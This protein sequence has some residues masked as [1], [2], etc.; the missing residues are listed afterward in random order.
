MT[1]WGSCLVWIAHEQVQQSWPN[2]GTVTM[3]LFT[4]ELR[5]VGRQAT[6]TS[7]SVSQGER[8]FRKGEGGGKEMMIS[9]YGLETS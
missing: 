4:T 6:L 2:K 8:A 9:T 1:H 3:G 7:R 5:V